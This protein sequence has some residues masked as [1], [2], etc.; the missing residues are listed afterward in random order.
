MLCGVRSYLSSYSVDLRITVSLTDNWIVQW[1]CQICPDGEGR[2]FSSSSL[3]LCPSH[4]L[5]LLLLLLFFPLPLGLSLGLSAYTPGGHFPFLFS[6]LLDRTDSNW[7]KK[8]NLLHHTW[9]L[10]LQVGSGGSNLVPAHSNVCA[11][12]VCQLF[13]HKTPLSNEQ[14]G[15]P[16]HLCALLCVSQ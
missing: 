13:A 5:L 4:A 16:N 9:S 7:D 3:P 6:I 12:W 1:H 15:L 2:D 10:P 14:R 11:N 8:E